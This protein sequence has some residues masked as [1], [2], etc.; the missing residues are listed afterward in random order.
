[1]LLIKYGNIFDSDCEAICNPINIFSI[2]GAGLAKQFK[3]RYPDM[4]L[5]YETI[6][7][8]KQLKVGKVDIFSSS[9]G[10]KI[11]LFPTKEHWKN[12]SKLVWIKDGLQDLLIKVKEYDIK[13]MAL[14]MLGC[15]LGGLKEKSVLQLIQEFACKIGEDVIVE[16]YIK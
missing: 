14:P 16:V 11:I 7:K 2:M 3:E 8:T 13:S 1:M 5:Y 9:N 6:C 10:K 15:G 12:P 4:F